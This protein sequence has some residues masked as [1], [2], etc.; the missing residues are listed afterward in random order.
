MTPALNL[1]LERSNRMVTVIRNGRF[2]FPDE[3]GAAPITGAPAAHCFD[4]MPHGASRN[5]VV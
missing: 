2:G 4:V 1:C 3:T 5:R